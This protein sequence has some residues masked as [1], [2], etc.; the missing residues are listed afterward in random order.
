MYSRTSPMFWSK[1]YREFRC[2]RCGSDAGYQSRPRNLLEKYLAP[3]FYLRPV[4]CGDCYGRSL[5]PM[6]VP[7]FKKREAVVIDHELAITAMDTPIRKEPDK[8]TS[9]PPPKRARIA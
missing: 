6:S 2:T 3:L 9:E 7:L 4:R 8:Q 5:R 1:F